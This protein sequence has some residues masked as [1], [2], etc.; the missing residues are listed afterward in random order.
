M[1]RPFAQML[2]RF[3]RQENANATVEFVILFPLL[4]VVLISTVE[5]GL[6]N[7]RQ[8]Q[9]E[10]A[11]DLTVRDLRLTTGSAPEHDDIRDQ[12]CD[13]SG[14]IDNCATSLRLEMVQ[15]DPFNWTPINTEPQC[16]E[17]IEDAQPVTDDSFVPGDSNDLMLIRACMKFE[18]VFSDWGL[19]DKLE[20]DPDGRVALYAASAFVQEPR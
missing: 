17:R 12:I 20:K 8:S 6:I 10:R 1:M 7:L 18:P 5:L 9:L 16:I 3:R 11:L 4:W 19:G 15:L 2:R 14:F 13:I